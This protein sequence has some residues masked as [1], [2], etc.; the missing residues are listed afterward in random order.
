MIVQNISL[1][2]YLKFCSICTRI[3]SVGVKRTA[4]WSGGCESEPCCSQFCSIISG[5][6]R[7]KCGLQNSKWSS[8]HSLDGVFSVKKNS[9]WDYCEAATE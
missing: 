1:L 2:K 4:L 5:I 6:A 3:L 8:M 7:Y 9:K